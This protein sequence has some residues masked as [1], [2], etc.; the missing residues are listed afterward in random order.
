MYLTRFMSIIKI[1]NYHILVWSIMNV[2]G[3]HVSLFVLKYPAFKIMIQKI[4]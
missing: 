1:V 3:R 2:Y 4:Y